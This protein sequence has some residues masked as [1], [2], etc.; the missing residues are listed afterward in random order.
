MVLLLFYYASLS[1]SCFW[2]KCLLNNYFHLLSSY[3]LILTC[4]LF[5]SVVDCRLSY[6]VSKVCLRVFFFSCIYYSPQ[7]LFFYATF[8]DNSIDFVSFFNLPPQIFSIGVSFGAPFFFFSQYSY[9]YLGRFFLIMKEFLFPLKLFFES[10]FL[11]YYFNC[12]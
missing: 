4:I 11:T 9:F 5:V 3:S 1:S 8:R 2:L 7:N 12:F 10:Q 6:S